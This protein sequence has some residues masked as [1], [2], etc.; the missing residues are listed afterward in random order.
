MGEV[1]IFENI[2][3]RND[4]IAGQNRK[5]IGRAF[6][7]NIMSSPG[8]G[9]TLILEKTAAALKKTRKLAV[10]EGDITT[11][12]DARRIRKQG[13]DAV[14]IKT[15]NYGG[16]CHLDAKMVSGALQKLLKKKTYDL[17]V[18]ENVGNLI[19][20][21]DF[22]LGEDKKVVALSATEGEDKPLKYPL[23]FEKAD[24]MILN[25]AD[26]LAHLDFDV[27]A[28]RANVK[29]VNR[30]LKIIEMSAKDGTGMRKWIAWLEAGIKAKRG[31]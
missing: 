22:N 20:P 25:K 8:A 29:K 30:G 24:L 23:M 6:S 17:I 14:Q 19:C 27:R 18:I 16:G 7:I 10:I 9:K 4:K 11:S 31:R 28:L 15:E 5:L 3:S 13:V 26:L 12:N 21:A 1:E 2:L